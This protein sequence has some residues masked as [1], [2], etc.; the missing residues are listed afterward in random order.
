MSQ[1]T[2]LNTP[3]VIAKFQPSRELTTTSEEAHSEVTLAPNQSS[4]KALEKVER[5]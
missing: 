1:E 5:V 3:A 2:S 4:E